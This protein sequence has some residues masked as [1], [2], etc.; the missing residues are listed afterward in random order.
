MVNFLKGFDN[1]FRLN[2]P[3]TKS[4]KAHSDI[5]TKFIAISPRYSAY[6]C[7]KTHNTL[8]DLLLVAGLP[9]TSSPSPS[10][11]F[12]QAKRKTTG[13]LNNIA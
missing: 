1:V 12:K 9:D 11:A 7:N 2:T 13:W 5:Y 10:G 6:N 8:I 3:P 4:R